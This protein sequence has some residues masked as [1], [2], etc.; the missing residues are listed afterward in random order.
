MIV[1][2]DTSVI[3]RRLIGEP[4]GLQP[5][6]GWD[7]VYTSVLTRV[8]YFRVIDR[9][10]LESKI[11]DAERVALQESFSIFWQTSYRVPLTDSILIRAA[12]PF[13]TIVGS[14]DALHLTSALA[15][16]ASGVNDM[17][18]LTHDKQLGRAAAA[19]ELPVRGVA[20]D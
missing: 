11:N 14:L 3:L 5:W 6:G 9:L 16:R 12:Q 2:M 20:L 13:P 17:T 4:G 10:R 8:E 1:Y 15:V 18:V 19:V 7:R